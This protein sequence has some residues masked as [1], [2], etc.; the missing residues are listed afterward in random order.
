MNH[1]KSTQPFAQPSPTLL[2]AARLGGTF[3]LATLTPSAFAHPGHAF[4]DQG[5]AHWVSSP[6]HA[7]VLV[8]A[9]I[10]LGALGRLAPRPLIRRL[11]YAGSAATL[12]LGLTVSGVLG[13]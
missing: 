10:L 2:R 6:D 9:S 5:P 1:S 3:L 7:L 11:A 4:M 8:V 12:I 13:S